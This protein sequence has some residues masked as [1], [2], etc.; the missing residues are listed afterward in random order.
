MSRPRSTPRERDRTPAKASPPAAI[1]TTPRARW[2]TR[3]LAVGT[4]AILALIAA[5]FWINR[6]PG[7]VPVPSVNLVGVDPSVAATIQ[8]QVGQVDR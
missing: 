7:N 5:V 2:G 3:W 6:G 8:K 1:A 4:V